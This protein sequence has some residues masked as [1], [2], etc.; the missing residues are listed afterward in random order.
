MSA[1]LITVSNPQSS[2]SS[3]Q[4][5]G[6]SQQKR[7]RASSESA[8]SF[9]YIEKNPLIRDRNAD[10]TPSGQDSA[11]VCIA[12]WSL[13]NNNRSRD[14]SRD[15][16]LDVLTA[17]SITATQ[18]AAKTSRKSAVER[19][20]VSKKSCVSAKLKA[21]SIPEAGNSFTPINNS[22][23]DSN[24]PKVVVS[25]AP[26]SSRQVSVQFYDFSNKD[27]NPKKDHYGSFIA[28]V[29]SNLQETSSD[30]EL[31][32]P[33]IK[34]HNRKLSENTVEN[35][36]FP[37]E[38]DYQAAPHHRNVIAT[39][40][41]INRERGLPQYDAHFRPVKLQ[42]FSPDGKC[43]ENYPNTPPVARSKFERQQ[44]L[45]HNQGLPQHMGQRGNPDHRL[46]PR[47][48][49]CLEQIQSPPNWKSAF[50]R[51]VKPGKIS[52]PHI[53]FSLPSPGYDR[54]VFPGNEFSV[55]SN[56]FLYR[57]DV[58]PSPYLPA[59]AFENKTYVDPSLSHK[60]PFCPSNSQLHTSSGR[61]RYHK[62]TRYNVPAPAIPRPDITSPHKSG[63]SYDNPSYEL[64]PIYYR[65]QGRYSIPEGE[66][67]PSLITSIHQNNTALSW[68]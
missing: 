48:P 34:H 18:S 47:F 42:T 52:D 30:S 59:V 1:K 63:R 14:R 26:C 11:N 4:L 3:S 61:R 39:S 6:T 50:S 19:L 55:P 45:P 44:V 46:N 41:G 21:Y 56:Q 67:R 33:A 17:D 8:H 54:S 60:V 25:Q 65:G 68:V 20:G 15:Q 27:Y 24:K 35:L 62:E 28:L 2:S 43:R 31:N 12:N 57:S 29:G 10:P 40:S 64:R 23:Y 13:N 5:P 16:T 53:S 37:N 9:S 22:S 49:N 32:A 7:N 36:D 58:I 38:A 51:N 66:K